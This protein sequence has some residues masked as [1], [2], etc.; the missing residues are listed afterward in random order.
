MIED[1]KRLGFLVSKNQQGSIYSS[2][3]MKLSWMQNGGEKSFSQD[4][5]S[6]I[7]DISTKLWFF[8]Y[9][10]RYSCYDRIG[11]IIISFCTFTNTKDLTW[12]AILQDRSGNKAKN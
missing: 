11:T 8:Q 5:D 3:S 12:A 6:G 9:F 7:H 4:V 10:F 2:H 1:F